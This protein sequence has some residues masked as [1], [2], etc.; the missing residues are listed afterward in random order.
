MG[1]KVPAFLTKVIAVLKGTVEEQG[2]IINKEK[3]EDDDYE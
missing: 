2:N 3:R 1:V